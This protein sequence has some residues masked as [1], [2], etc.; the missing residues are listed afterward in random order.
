MKMRSTGGKTSE[1]TANKLNPHR[2]R[3][4]NSGHIG[5]KFMFPKVNMSPNFVSLRKT[6]YELN[7]IFP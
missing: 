7:Q 1:Q 5:R 3:K 2:V 6:L 4:S